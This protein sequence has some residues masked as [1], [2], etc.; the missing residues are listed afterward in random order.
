M[1]TELQERAT[2]ILDANPVFTG[3]NFA[4]ALDMPKGAAPVGRLLRQQVAAQRI[5]RLH[6]EVF[7]AVL[8]HKTPGRLVLPDYVY[9]SKY[10][11]DG[12]LGYHTGLR[13]FGIQ[14]SAIISQVQVISRGPTGQVERTTLLFDVFETLASDKILGL[15]M[16]PVGGT[17]LNE[18]RAGVSRERTSP[19]S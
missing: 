9:A 19:A 11:P 18:F 14:Y 10:R 13:L 4:A 5:K 1:T 7:A 17:A 16:M 3:D 2:S 15:R 6:R 8:D 12:V